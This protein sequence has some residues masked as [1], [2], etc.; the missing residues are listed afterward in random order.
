VQINQSKSEK[1]LDTLMLAHI[2]NINQLG[3]GARTANELAGRAMLEL[4][5]AGVRY[6]WPLGLIVLAVA[7]CLSGNDSEAVQ[8]FNEAQQIAERGPMPLFLADVHLHRAR[9]F[10][11]ETELAKAAKL[12]RDLGYGRRYDELADAEEAAKNW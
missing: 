7:A 10:R 9:M 4:R 1:A 6:F 3:L 12:I 8:A 11:D 2:Y 5:S